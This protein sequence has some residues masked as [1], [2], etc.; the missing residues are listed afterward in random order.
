MFIWWRA[1]HHRNDI[2]FDKGDASIDNS[3]RFL[4]NY[5][6][7]LQNIAHGCETRD[8]K[9]KEKVHQEKLIKHHSSTQEKEVKESWGKPEEGWVKC[10]VDA[11]FSSSDMAGAWGA[12]LRDHNGSIIASAW[13]RINHCNSAALGEAI[14]CLEGLK[15]S[16]AH[17]DSDIIIETDCSA[18]LEAFKEDS[19]NR[20]EVRLIAKEFK[21]KKPP[22]RQVNLLKIS[23]NCNF[24]AHDLCQFG[25]REL[26]GGVLKSSVPECVSKSALNDCNKNNVI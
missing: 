26:S 25:R 1:W 11:S 2:I 10:N 19:T 9:G 24:A 3:I 4:Q 23:R 13:D 18:V 22:D 21:L 17:S 15:L 8:R 7:S 16:L 12:I 5:L 20:T 6:A 14:A